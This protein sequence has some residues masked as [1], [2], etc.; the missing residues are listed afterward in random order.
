MQLGTNEAISDSECPDMKNI[1]TTTFN[2]CKNYC[3]STTGCDAFNIKQDNTDCILRNCTTFPPTLVEWDNYNSWALCATGKL[4]ECVQ[5][6]HA[7]FC[8][9]KISLF[10]SLIHCRYS[11]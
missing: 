10:I 9:F 2:Q 11:T 1:A 4:R 8:L 6:K 7:C 5:R 3:I